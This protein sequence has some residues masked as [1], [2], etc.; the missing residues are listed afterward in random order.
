MSDEDVFTPSLS[1]FDK[2]VMAAA[3]STEF[4]ILCFAIHCREQSYQRVQ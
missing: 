4:Y 2:E 3:T 1:F